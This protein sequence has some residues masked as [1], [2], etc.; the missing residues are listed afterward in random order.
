MLKADCIWLDQ[1]SSCTALAFS[2]YSLSELKANITK[3]WSTGL[4]IF[5]V[6]ALPQLSLFPFETLPL[7]KPAKGQFLPRSCSR[8]HYMV[9]KNWLPDLPH[10]LSPAFLSVTLELFFSACF[11]R[12][13][14]SGFINSAVF[15]LLHRQR[16]PLTVFLKYLFK[17]I[18]QILQI[19]NPYFPEFYFPNSAMEQQNQPRSVVTIK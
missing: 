8:P 19:H 13:I 2:I 17:K 3:K 4:K 10:D 5:Q 15:G 7:R 11:A 14:K 9:F 18:A 16:N 6:E 1:V 12:F